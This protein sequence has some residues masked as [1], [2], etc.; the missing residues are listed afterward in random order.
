F[1]SQSFRYLPTSYL[2]YAYP[3]GTSQATCWADSN[4]NAAGNTIEEAAVQGF[5]ELVERDA[6]AIWWYNQLSRPGVDLSSFDH[7]YVGK[8][9]DFYG[10]NRRQ[11]WALDLTTDFAIPTFAA[12]SRRIDQPSEEIIFGF[13]SHLD[14]RVALVRAITEMNQFLPVV[15]GPIGPDGKR[16]I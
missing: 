11:L 12:V 15:D 10:R 13:G 4:G 14:A 1:G 3:L 16:V 5:L 7:P 9:L 8:C 6:I 2:Y